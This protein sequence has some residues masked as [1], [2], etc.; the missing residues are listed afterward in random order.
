MR[1]NRSGTLDRRLHSPLVAILLTVAGFALPGVLFRLEVPSGHASGH[2]Y[3]RM[4]LL[5]LTAADS[6][7]MRWLAVHDP[8]RIARGGALPPP[9]PRTAPVSAARPDPRLVIPGPRPVAPAAFPVG[10]IPADAP[11]RTDVEPAAV[12]YPALPPEIYPRVTVNGVK[13]AGALP[14]ELLKLAASVNAGTAELRFSYGILPG[15]LRV[16]IVRSS[17]NVRVDQELVRQFSGMKFPELPARVR[18]VWDA[19]GEA[20]GEG[21]K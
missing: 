6:G 7:M 4:S 11:P 9:V 2:H 14:E 12:D 8:T 21:D 1:S 16:A 19:A 13:N 18:V 10:P 17:G 5:P 20:A 3:G 15:E